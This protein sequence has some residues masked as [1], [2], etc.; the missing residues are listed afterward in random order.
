MAQILVELESG[1]PTITAPKGIEVKVVDYDSYDVTENSVEE[2]YPTN[3]ID[4]DGLEVYGLLNTNQIKECL[5]DT[6]EQV[7]M[8]SWCV[9]DVLPMAEFEEIELTRDEAYEILL[10]V[11]NEFDASIGV[12]WE[13]I[14][15]KLYEY[16]VERDKDS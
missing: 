12:N 5:N 8:T 15:N 6:K 14:R 3:S 9:D 7:V 2:S 11:R 16:V 10:K 4:P 13:V 1:I